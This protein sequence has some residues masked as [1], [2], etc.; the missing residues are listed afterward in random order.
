MGTRGGEK[1][2]VSMERASL[3]VVERKKKRETG[4]EKERVKEEK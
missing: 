2:G 1:R 4:K 3:A